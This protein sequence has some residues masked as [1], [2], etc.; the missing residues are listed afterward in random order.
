MRNIIIGLIVAALLLGAMAFYQG[1]WERLSE[2][3]LISGKTILQVFPILIISFALSGLISVL[4]S[5]DAV[6]RWLGKESGLKG[7]ILA[8]LAGALVPGGPYVFFPIAATFLVSGAEIGTVI[9]FITAKNL[10]T[11]SRLPIEIALL[12]TGVTF[13]R[14]IVTFLFPIFLGLMANILFSGFTE[15]IRT[16]IKYLQN[17]VDASEAIDNF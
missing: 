7:L 9:C 10:W 17:S 14:Y 11:L 13:I 5:K 16:K 3:L 6:S 15:K 2:G 12:G 8:G 1:G 4:I